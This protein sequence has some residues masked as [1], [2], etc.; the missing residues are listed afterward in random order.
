MPDKH[1]TE[2]LIALL[3]ANQTRLRAYVLSLTANPETA[4]EVLQ[5]T[6]LVIWRKAEHFEPGSNFVAWA[7]KIARLQV[8]AH[9]NKSIREKTLFSE[10]FI[11]ELSSYVSEQETQEELQEVQSALGHCLEEFPENRKELLWLRYRDNLRIA[12]VAKQQGKKVGA[13]KQLFHRMRQVLLRCIER[14]LAEGK[15]V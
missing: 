12:E 4:M 11:D 6:N 5:A 9:R 15:L 2:E 13:I 1:E 3:T 8:K 10:E 14:R 7:F